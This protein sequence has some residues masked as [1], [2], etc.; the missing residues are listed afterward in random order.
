MDNN[1][2]NNKSLAKKKNSSW[3]LGV[4]SIG[5]SLFGSIIITNIT[6][7]LSINGITTYSET[8][9]LGKILTAVYYGLLLIFSIIGFIRG[10]KELKA[11]KRGLAVFGLIMCFIS[12]I[13]L[14][15]VGWILLTFYAG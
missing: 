6:D 8:A 9:R 7:H 13:V 15:S 10:I 14:L 1:L 11:T 4:V 12:I 3:I 5:L 2:S